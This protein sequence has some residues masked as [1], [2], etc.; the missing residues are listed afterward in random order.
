[1]PPPRAHRFVQRIIAADGAELLAVARAEAF[2]RGVVE[3]DFADRRSTNLSSA[4]VERC[5]SGSKLLRLSTVSPKKSK[6]IGCAPAGNRS[7]MPPRTA[8]SPG[9]RTV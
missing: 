3:Q 9:S 1:M 7:T 8:N 5:V 4:P 6:R 2:D